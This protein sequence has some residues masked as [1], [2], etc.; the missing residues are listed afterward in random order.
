M[1]KNNATLESARKIYH[2]LNL[3]DSIVTGMKLHSFQSMLYIA[4]CS[5]EEMSVFMKWRRNAQSRKHPDTCRRRLRVLGS[6][7]ERLETERDTL[8]REKR[9]LQLEI[10]SMAQVLMQ[11]KQNV[12]I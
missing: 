10:D 4:N 1:T 7:I 2:Q 12:S 9:G 3:N 6:D 8:A 5:L 11:D